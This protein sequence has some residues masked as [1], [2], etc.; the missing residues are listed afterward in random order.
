MS[1]QAGLLRLPPDASALKTLLGCCCWQ[2][3]NA[4]QK[5][6]LGIGSLCARHEGKGGPQ[7]REVCSEVW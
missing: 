1:A 4:A 7:P 6:G 5:S 3:S 2:C